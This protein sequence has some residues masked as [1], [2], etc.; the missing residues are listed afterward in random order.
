MDQEIIIMKGGMVVLEMSILNLLPIKLQDMHNQGMP[1]EEG[2]VVLNS[3]I[4]A[5]VGLVGFQ[6]LGN[7]HFSCC[8]CGKNQ[9]SRIMPL[10]H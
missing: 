10:L 6:M 9:N 5:D 7:L 8:F 1:G 2:Y 4:L 3:K